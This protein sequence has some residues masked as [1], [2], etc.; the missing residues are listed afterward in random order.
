MVLHF[1]LY[2]VFNFLITWRFVMALKQLLVHRASCASIFVSNNLY[3]LQVF[4]GQSGGPDSDGKELPRLV[5]I[6]R[7]KNP[8]HEH[9]KKAGA[10][11]ALVS[12][13]RIRI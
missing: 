3:F 2:C 11:N 1:L 8:K 4:L 7:E 5:Y 13:L 9:H 10:M 12:N 6:S